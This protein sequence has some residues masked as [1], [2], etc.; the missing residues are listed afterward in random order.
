MEANLQDGRGEGVVHAPLCSPPPCGEGLGVGVV[1]VE[2]DRATPP[3]PPPPRPPPPPPPPPPRRRAPPVAPPHKGEVKKEI[4]AAMLATTCASR[5]SRCAGERR[6]LSVSENRA[7]LPF[8]KAA[9]TVWC[10]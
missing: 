5:C 10:T 3:P 4:Y 6:P 2:H 7:S 9:T 8:S 1:R